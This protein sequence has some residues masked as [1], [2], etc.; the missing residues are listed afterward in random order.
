MKISHLLFNISTAFCHCQSLLCAAISR[1]DHFTPDFLVFW[2]SL[3]CSSVLFPKPQMRNHVCCLQIWM[4]SIPIN[5]NHFL[6]TPLFFFFFFKERL[7]KQPRQA[8]SSQPTS[9]ASQVL[10]SSH[11]PASLS[12]VFFSFMFNIKQT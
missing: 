1:R 11:V 10:G 6:P 3:P 4:I 9:S 5:P 7:P 2:L 12:T 8:S